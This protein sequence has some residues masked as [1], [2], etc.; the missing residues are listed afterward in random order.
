VHKLGTHDE[1]PRNSIAVYRTIRQTI[2]NYM[3]CCS[4][5]F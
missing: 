1:T 5:D 4:L 2:T 3:P